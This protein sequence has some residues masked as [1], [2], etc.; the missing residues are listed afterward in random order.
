MYALK[1]KDPKLWE[2]F[3]AGD[4]VVNKSHL[5]SCAIGVDHALEQVNR[6]MKVSGLHCWDNAESDCTDE[7]LSSS[8]RTGKLKVESKQN[9][10]IEQKP[11]TKHYKLSNAACNKLFVPALSL[12][13]TLQ[14]YT[15]PFKY[16]GDDIMNMTVVANDVKK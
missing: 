11:S 1:D 14:A 4:L 16:D 6:W 13:T 3:T 5:A 10:G 2:E 8:P 9:S 7:V 12:T 15:N